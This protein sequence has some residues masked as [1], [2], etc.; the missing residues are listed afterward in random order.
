MK[1]QLSSDIIPKSINNKMQIFIY[2]WL[3]FFPSPQNAIWIDLIGIL[4]VNH[5]SAS[6]VKV[7]RSNP[8]L[9][10]Q[11]RKKRREKSRHQ[12]TDKNENRTK[13]YDC[14]WREVH[15][16]KGSEGVKE[17]DSYLLD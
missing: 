13:N 12:K 10:R 17:L 5:V 16:D 8:C 4:T 11:S 6:I 3:F 9:L 15:N 14:K 7:K 1:E 2:K